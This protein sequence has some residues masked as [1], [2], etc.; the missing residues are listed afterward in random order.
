MTDSNGFDD[1]TD[2]SA[3]EEPEEP[4]LRGRYVKGD[5]GTAGTER[6]R[7]TDDEE[8][9]Y[10]QGYFGG[11]GRE[12]GLPEP[13]GSKAQ[14]AGRFVKGNYGLAGGAG[15][16]TAESETGRYTEGDYGRDGTVDPTRKAATGTEQT[17][18]PDEKPST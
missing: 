11:A 15:G 18:G 1:P 2:E 16:R 14:E 17:A 9:Q 10:I 13:L 6:G 3:G 5:Y 12:G 4:E 7:H 8:G